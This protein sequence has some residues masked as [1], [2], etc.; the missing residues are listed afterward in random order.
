[1]KRKEIELERKHKLY[2]LDPKPEDL[3][4]DKLKR[5][6]ES[7]RAELVFVAINLDDLRFGVKG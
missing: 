6:I 2:E 4:A 5:D 1:M 7:R 3:V